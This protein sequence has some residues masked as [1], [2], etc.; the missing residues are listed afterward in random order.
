MT[1]AYYDIETEAIPRLEGQRAI[2]TIHSIA[3]AVDD[4][5]PLVFTSRPTAYSDGPL[6]AAVTLINSCKYA[7]GHN[8]IGFD[9]PV[10]A[11]LLGIPITSTHLDTM[12]LAKLTYNKDAL[13]KVD[14]SLG[15]QSDPEL[16]KLMGSYGLTA[17]GL[18]L[19]NEKIDF[20]D[21]SQLSEEMCVYNKQDVAVTRDLLQVL[22]QQE[23]YPIQAVIDLEMEA[24]A[25]VQLIAT[26]GFYVNRKAAEQLRDS[27]LH[28][29]FT[30]RRELLA[31]YKPL[32]LPKVVQPPHTTTP[33]KARKL[34]TWVHNPYHQG[35]WVWR[36]PTTLNN[37][38]VKQPD[39]D[40]E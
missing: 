30:I 7:V 38:L 40:E 29:K 35:Y 16:K 4:A 28:E 33:A 1:Y 22:L 11:N 37:K 34:R 15:W 23:T 36:G 25:V 39:T 26:N 24:A 12:I 21:W 20:E 5:E 3:V 13:Y 31:K 27:L 9:A 14:Y 10:I 32:Y 8:S 2:R 18:R 6:S 17:F 19:G